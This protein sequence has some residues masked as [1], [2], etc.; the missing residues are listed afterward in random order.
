MVELITKGDPGT[1]PSLIPDIGQL[2]KGQTKDE[3]YL[4][5]KGTLCIFKAISKRLKKKE[6]LTQEASHKLL[7]FVEVICAK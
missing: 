7:P 2:L 4:G 3:L 5:L 6:K 1:W